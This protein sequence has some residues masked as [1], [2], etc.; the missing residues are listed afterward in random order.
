MSS[1]DFVFSGNCIIFLFV[2]L[3]DCPDLFLETKRHVQECDLRSVV[4]GPNQWYADNFDMGGGEQM[5]GACKN[6]L[7]SPLVS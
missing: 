1:C 4:S 3:T 7:I 5:L 6:I 2:L